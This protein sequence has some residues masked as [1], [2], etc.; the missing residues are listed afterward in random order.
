MGFIFGL[1]IMAFL[2][3]IIL[4]TIG[5]FASGHWIFAT[6]IIIIAIAALRK[7]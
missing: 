5:A 7:V 4:I 6:L 1:F 2:V 3:L